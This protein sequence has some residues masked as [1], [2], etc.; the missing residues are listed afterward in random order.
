MS[1]NKMDKVI[2]SAIKTALGLTAAGVLATAPEAI[3][4]GEIKG[5]EKCYG[6]AKAGMNDCGTAT[7]SCAATSKID[8]QG[9]AWIYLPEGTCKKIV[10]GSLEPRNKD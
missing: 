1:K 2:K 8:G 10:G 3:A 5:K 7:T 4:H 9:D 6:I